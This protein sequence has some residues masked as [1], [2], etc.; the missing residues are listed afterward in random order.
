M[1][2][3]K[4][5]TAYPSQ[6]LTAIQRAIDLGELVIPTPNPRAMQLQF[7]GLRGCL[8]REGKSE[9]AEMVSF[10]IADNPPRLILRLRELSPLAKDI[11]AALSAA[12]ERSAADEALA[13]LDRIL[14]SSQP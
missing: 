4:H 7:N 8:R 11:T 2:T 9:F 1:T 12:P 14:G 3:P 5:S 10:I 6:M 13:A